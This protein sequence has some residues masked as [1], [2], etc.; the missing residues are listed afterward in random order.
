MTDERRLIRLPEVLRICG[1]S[2]ATWYNGI[3]AGKFPRPIKI[4]P[5]TSG[6]RLSDVHALIEK[7]SLQAA[8]GGR[9]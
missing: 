8:D 3:A 9:A 6:W 2:R 4:T 5:R 1:F 7:A